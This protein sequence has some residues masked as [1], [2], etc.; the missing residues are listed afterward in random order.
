MIRAD[1]IPPEVKR[2]M[3]VAWARRNNGDAPEKVM[4]DLAVAALSAWP[5]AVIDGPITLNGR[6]LAPGCLI[7]PLP[8]EGGTLID[9]V[10]L[11]TWSH[12]ASKDNCCATDP[13]ENSDE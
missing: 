13:Q 8:Q 3:R 7:L 11:E 10:S 9:R 5:S 1:Q 2:A 12:D 6:R 4:T